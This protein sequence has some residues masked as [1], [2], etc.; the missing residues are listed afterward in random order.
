M[1]FAKLDFDELWLWSHV[2]QNRE[3]QSDHKT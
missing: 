2:T 1:G 3:L